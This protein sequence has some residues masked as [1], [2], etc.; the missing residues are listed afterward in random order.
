M[1][2]VISTQ[3]GIQIDTVKAAFMEGE[4]IYPNASFHEKTHI[5]ICVCDSRRIKGVFRVSAHDIATR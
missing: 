5:Q 1:A 3:Q 2:R 4:P